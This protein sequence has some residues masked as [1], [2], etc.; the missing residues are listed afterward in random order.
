MSGNKGKSLASYTYSCHLAESSSSA[1]GGYRNKE[2]VQAEQVKL[3]DKRL[4]ILEDETELL[5][6]AFYES[7]EERR[8]LVHAIQNEFQAVCNGEHTFGYTKRQRHGLP[9]ILGEDTNP[10]VVFRELRASEAV[11]QDATVCVCEFSHR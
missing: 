6:V 8:R 10:A 5:K 4:R 1:E 11:F 7:V 9:Q 3:V 2:I